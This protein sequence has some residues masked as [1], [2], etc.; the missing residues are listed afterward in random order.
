MFNPEVQCSVREADVIEKNLTYVHSDHCAAL[1]LARDD[2]CVYM[3]IEAGELQP[4]LR[5]IF[6]VF[7]RVLSSFRSLELQSLNFQI[8]TSTKYTKSFI[9]A[10]A[11]GFA[12]VNADFEI[13]TGQPAFPAAPSGV[14]GFS[15]SKSVANDISTGIDALGISLLN[16][17][18]FLAEND[19]ATSKFAEFVKT[20]TTLGIPAEVTDTANVVTFTTIPP[21]Y[22]GVPDEVKKV[23]DDYNSLLSGVYASAFAKATGG[24]APSLASPTSSTTALPSPLKPNST[25][26]ITT[27]PP[28]ST[29]P[30]GAGSHLA[31]GASAF[32]AAAGAAIMFAL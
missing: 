22:S 13:I 11:L 10:V 9:V 20:A 26:T 28:S 4:E 29:P 1:A 18:S 6:F 7:F 14:D 30:S 5:S 17:T 32:L 25:T 27:A 3:P 16:G 8:Q 21:W 15:W 23:N 19:V 24:S 12:G 2:K 31:V